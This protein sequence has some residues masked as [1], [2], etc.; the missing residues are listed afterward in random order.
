MTAVDRAVRRVP[1]SADPFYAPLPTTA[2]PGTVLRVRD[3]TVATQVACLAY[4]VVYASTDTLGRATAMSGTV[5]VPEPRWPGHPPA[6]VSFGVGVHGLA[7]DAAPSHQL[8]AGTEA[9]L[10]LIEA[11]LARGWAVAVA[12]GEGLGMPGPHTYGAGRAGGHAMLDIARAAVQA[13]PGLHR[14]TP[15]ALWGY[16]EGGRCATWAAELAP[17]YAPELP[18]VALAAGGVPTDL[19]VVA[20]A[21][22]EGPFAG[23]NLA[24][25]VGLARAHERPE[26]LEILTERGLRAA[27]RAADL[28]V[29]GLVLGCRRP[30]AT[31]T[32]RADPWDDPAW[33]ELL[34]RERAGRGLPRVPVYLYHADQDGI[35]PPQ[36]GRDLARSYRDR[37]AD[38]TAVEVEAPDHL[39]GGHLGAA[40]ALR[41]LAGYLPVPR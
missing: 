37:G 35:V 23:L 16:S 6:L 36:L 10:P 38:V 40:G 2:A 13:T 27:R 33:R 26:L 11:A 29:I 12:D 30:L 3:V 9:E 21:I 19:Y 20:R 7:R 39:S 15:V 17:T 18:L 31:L 22:D 5:L 1:P 34:E 41:W 25:L 8:V 24:V 28:D 32:V 4:Q 14:A